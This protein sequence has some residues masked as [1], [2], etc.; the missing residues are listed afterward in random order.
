MQWEVSIRKTTGVLRNQYLQWSIPKTI[1]TRLQLCDGDEVRLT[2]RHK[3]FHDVRSYRITSG[4]EI[5]LPT[6]LA[7]ALRASA[8]SH[9]NLPISFSISG[10]TSGQSHDDSFYQLVAKSRKSSRALRLSRLANAPRK[11]AIVQRLVSVFVRNPDVVAEVLDRA[12]GKCERCPATAPFRRKSDG[13][14]YLE[15]HHRV[16]LSAGGDD[17]VENS[18]ALCPNCH[19][20]LHYG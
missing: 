20:E 1:R 2:L 15:V 3:A 6:E 14:P 13:T 9:P 10:E 8:E 18:I 19:R 4:G 11:P 12:D 5:R 17:T 16:Q 7:S